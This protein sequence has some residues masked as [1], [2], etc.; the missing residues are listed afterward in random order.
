MVLGRMTRAV[1]NGQGIQDPRVSRQHLKISLAHGEAHEPNGV[2]RVQALGHNPSTIK[3]GKLCARTPTSHQGDRAHLFPVV[4]VFAAA[5][6][7]APP[8][9]VALPLKSLRAPVCDSR[10]KLGLGFHAE[11]PSFKLRRGDGSTVG[12]GLPVNLYPGDIIQLVC[13]DVSR[14]HGRSL[15]FEG[16]AC[17]YL[18]DFLP[19]S[20][21]EL[22][23][24][25][26]VLGKEVEET[27]GEASGAEESAGEGGA[28][29]SPPEASQQPA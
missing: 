22:P 16:N 1:D 29:G 11:P 24:G 17:A 8:F 9:R 4:P 23:P 12:G 27:D 15:P 3:R 2:C 14:A 21:G 18:V 13:E 20:L 19:D 5:S 26:V 7:L 10:A 28:P 6:F 25:T